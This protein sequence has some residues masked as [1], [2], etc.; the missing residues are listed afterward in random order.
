MEYVEPVKA[1][2]MPGLRL[3]LTCHAPAPYSMSAKAILDLK[4]VPYVPVAQHG[5]GA[6]SELLDWTRYRNAPVAVH[7]IPATKHR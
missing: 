4:Q 5:A 7:N 6:N 2:D 3:A 1:K